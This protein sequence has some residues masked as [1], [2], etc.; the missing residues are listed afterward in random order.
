MS[1]D[2]PALLRRARCLSA[3]T[4]SIRLAVP[5]DFPAIA[6]VERAAA[7]MFAGT[8]MDWAV[9]APPTDPSWLAAAWGRGWLWVAAASG[10]R[11]AGFL[12]AAPLARDLFV[13]ELSVHPDLHR[14]GIGTALLAQAAVAA[15][16]AGLQGVA[17]TTDRTLPW[18]APFYA[19][20]GFILQDQPPP[21]LRD[22]LAAESHA[23]MDPRQRCAMRL[24]L[25]E[26]Q[27]AV[28]EDGA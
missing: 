17:L 27:Q 25:R 10:G 18:N 22:R 19:R 23:G 7:Q 2:G 14:Q 24:D 21:A 4:A 3:N 16:K 26:A 15:Q 11:I 1:G 6:A 13:Q 20:L 8:H 12:M 9:D 5:A 28:D